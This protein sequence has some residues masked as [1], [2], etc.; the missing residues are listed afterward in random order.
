MLGDVY[1]DDFGGDYFVY[2][3]N[4]FFDVFFVVFVFIVVEFKS[5]VGFGVC[6]V[7]N[8]GFVYVYWG[9]DFDFNCWV[10]F[11]C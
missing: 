9:V 3:F 8:G 10:F 5:F 2:V 1:F 6:F 11:C 7:W 4:G